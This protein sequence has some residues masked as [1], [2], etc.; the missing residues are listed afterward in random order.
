MMNDD[1]LAGR[2]VEM[3]LKSAHPDPELPGYD[4]A[5]RIV[6][7]MDDENKRRLTRAFWAMAEGL[8]CQLALA[9]T[10]G[11]VEV[12]AYREGPLTA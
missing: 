6:S 2:L 9:E 4:T 11:R 5:R 7:A 1:E 8:E 12:A 3:M 10:D